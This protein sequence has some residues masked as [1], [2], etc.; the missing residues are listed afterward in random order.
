MYV[1]QLRREN[2]GRDPGG[3]TTAADTWPTVRSHDHLSVSS[4]TESNAVVVRVP[5]RRLFSAKAAAE[6]LGVHQRTLKKITARGELQAR[7]IGLRCVYC[8]EDLDR[9]IESLPLSA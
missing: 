2:L 1:G 8:L 6:Y 9:Y 4:M 7:T 3:R 5:K